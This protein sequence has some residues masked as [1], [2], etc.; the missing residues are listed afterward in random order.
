MLINKS[1]SNCINCKVNYCPVL[2][3]VVLNYVCIC[4][5]YPIGLEEVEAEKMG[6]CESC[7]SKKGRKFKSSIELIE[8]Y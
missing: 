2:E 7:S 5:N 3:G 1:F 4:N 6:R 8:T